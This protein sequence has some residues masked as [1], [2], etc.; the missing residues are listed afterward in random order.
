MEICRFPKQTIKAGEV[1]LIVNTELGEDTNLAAGM[2]VGVK[3]ED[4]V[5]GAGPHKY[6]KIDKFEI[7]DEVDG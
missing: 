5:R 3:K 2:Q 4:Q 7:P 6:L 1:W